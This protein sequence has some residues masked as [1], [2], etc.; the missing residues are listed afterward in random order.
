LVAYV[1][2]IAG[3]FLPLRFLAGLLEINVGAIALVENPFG[4]PR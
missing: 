1:A 4:L 2:N 3:L